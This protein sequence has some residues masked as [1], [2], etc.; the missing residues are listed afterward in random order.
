MNIN[1]RSK[2]GRKRLLWAFLACLTAAIVALLASVPV[3]AALSL[4]HQFGYRPATYGVQLEQHLKVTTNDGTILVGDLYRPRTAAAKPVILVRIPYS[5]TW[6]N[7]LFARTLGHLWAS[8]GYNVLIQAT[9]GRYDSGGRYVPM[10]HEAADGQ[11]TLDWI[12]QQPW[13]N[14]QVAMWGGSYFGYT[15]WVL[16]NGNN[17]QLAAIIPQICSTSFYKM[18]YPGGAF[19]FESAL[20]WATMSYGEQD[21]PQSPAALQRGYDGFPLIE[22]DDRVV[23]DID[24][25]NDWASHRQ[26]DDPY[27][28]EIDG[29]NRAAA[30]T[31]PALLMAGWYDP[32]LPSQLDDWQQIQSAASP[33]IA[34]ASRLVIGPW[35]HA[36]SVTWPDGTTPRNYRLESIEPSLPWFDQ[37]LSPSH[38]DP[39]INRLTASQITNP[40]AVS[41]APIQLYVMGLNQWRG[42]QTWPLERTQYQNYYLHSGGHANGAQGDGRLSLT[43]PSSGETD[44]NIADRFIYDPSNPVSSAGG[45][46]LG[47]RSG[48]ALQ[49][50][51]ETR[52]D[53]LVYTTPP[54]A[55]ELEVTGPVQL[56]LSVSTTA[57]NTDF[58]AKLVDVY[59]D[60]S[61]YNVSDGILRRDYT[62]EMSEGGLQLNSNVPATEIQ[63]DLWPTSQLFRRGHRIRLEV[64]S[65]NYPR[66]DRNPNMGHSI[67]SE[68][69]YSIAKQT[70]Y[71]DHGL[72]S[73]LV[74]PIIKRQS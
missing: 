34:A 21:I 4:A 24:F 51:A 71:H 29:H 3:L 6:R 11:A 8:R 41:E 57:P 10:I 47:P 66:F 16:A 53:V 28:Q 46:M 39:P 23:Q 58:T 13:Y 72:V 19:S 50:Q 36:Q 37:Q 27:W 14:G 35:T 70:V 67:P 43:P 64:S 65:S 52:D 42:E 68:A 69:Q 54:L 38:S 15:Q 63:I 17:P 62:P 40:T 26:E 22:A 30:L 20:Y 2:T 32:F 31:A 44:S 12:A 33:E 5:K 1:Q 60:G 9:R 74:L 49:N 25:F 45:T 48:I 59:P 7:R 18:F 61:A 56:I 73:R 55:K